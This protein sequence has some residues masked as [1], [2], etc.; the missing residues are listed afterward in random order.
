LAVQGVLGYYSATETTLDPRTA[1]ACRLSS[2]P[3][4]SPDLL[5]LPAPFARFEQE[6][7]ANH[8]TPYSYDTHVPLILLGAPF[9]PGRYRGR[10]SPADLAPTLASALGLTPPA[11]S[12]GRVLAEAL[13]DQDGRR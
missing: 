13:R 3:S 5:V 11:L 10:V 4:R 8:G 2:Y 12:T 7:A 9:R 6:D 1:E